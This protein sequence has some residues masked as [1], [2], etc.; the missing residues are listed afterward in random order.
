[1]RPPIASLLPCLLLL[2]LPQLAACSRSGCGSRPEE[3][4]PVPARAD[5][6]RL[7]PGP[8]GDGEDFVV[9]P[10]CGMRLRRGEAAATL[11][12]NGQ[13]YYFCL[14]DHMEAFRRD[15]D[16]YLSESQGDYGPDSED[17]GGGGL[18]R[19]V[20]AAADAPRAGA[21]DGGGA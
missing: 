15:P 6:A 16:R 7:T 11:E 17:G 13:T 10:Y 9:D 1:M 3:P 5:A 4:A 8:P 12:H 2:L 21:S 19:S 20:D 14:E 18:P